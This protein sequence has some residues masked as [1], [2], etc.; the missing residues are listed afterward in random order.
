MPLYFM[1][2]YQHWMNMQEDKMWSLNLGNSPA[3]AKL[4]ISVSAMQEGDYYLFSVWISC[5]FSYNWHLCNIFLISLFWKF[6]S[7]LRWE[8]TGGMSYLWFLLLCSLAVSG[9]C[10][11]NH[12]SQHSQVQLEN[13]QELSRLHSRKYCDP[14]Y[15]N[16]TGGDIQV[17]NCMNSY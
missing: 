9:L 4:N 2:C 16:H 3:Q 15:N 7:E 10:L 14:T 5:T 17:R 13:N 6:M 12:G 8:I 1:H 11:T